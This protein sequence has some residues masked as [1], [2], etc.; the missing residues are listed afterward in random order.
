MSN[1]Q[2][3][4]ARDVID[5]LDLRGDE[6]VLDAGCGTGRVTEVLAQR[7]PNGTVI[8][9]MNG[10]CS[11]WASVT[12]PVATIWPPGRLVTLSHWTMPA[13]TVTQT[14]W[15]SPTRLA[16]LKTSIEMI[17]WSPTLG[18]G[19]PRS[20]F[21][22]GATTLPVSWKVLPLSWA[23]APAAERARATIGMGRNRMSFMRSQAP[24]AA[25][26]PRQGHPRDFPRAPAAAAS[27]S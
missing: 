21:A 25:L 8:A 1:P 6:R 24:G 2:L 22:G 16:P 15:L 10:D 19:A 11:S 14:T 5:R 17:C 23:E 20:M 18:P 3:A 7:V 26:S 13:R 9:W 12:R 4:M 27:A